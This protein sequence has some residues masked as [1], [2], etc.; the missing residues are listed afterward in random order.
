MKYMMIVKLSG[1]SE[2]RRNY[3]NGAPPVPELMAAMEELQKRTTASGVMVDTGGLFPDAR[4]ARIKAT[5]GKLTVKDG[6]F[7]ESKE[8][9]G[10]YAILKV[11]SKQEAI[12]C[13]KEFMQIHLDILGPA[14]EAE[15]EVREMAAHEAA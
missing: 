4:G 8:V 1:D 12:Q 13:G 7:T 2:T 15:M 3:E 6:P 9:I 14:W 5:K 11:K 10:G